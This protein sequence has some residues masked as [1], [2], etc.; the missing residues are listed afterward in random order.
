MLLICPL[1]R[2]KKSN[3]STD[4]QERFWVKLTFRSVWVGL[5]YLLFGCQQMVVAGSPDAVG[6][7]AQVAPLVQETAPVRIAGLDMPAPKRVPPPDVP[8]L[9]IDN[10][11]IEVIHFGKT[12]GLE[13]NGGYISVKDVKSGKELWILEVYHIEYDEKMEE[14]VQDIFIES[15]A[16]GSVP[17]TVRVVDE[18][19]RKFIVDLKTRKSKREDL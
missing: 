17:G 9:V 12:R 19:N 11:E 1:G 15:L 5:L 10:L 8:P 13:Q 4:A 16:K 7:D 6:N 18:R 14:D 2:S 3:V